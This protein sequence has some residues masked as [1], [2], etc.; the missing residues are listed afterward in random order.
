MGS[1]RIGDWPIR[2]RAKVGE[3]RDGQDIFGDY[4]GFM[5]IDDPNAVPPY[6]KPWG[7]PAFD[8][9][10]GARMDPGLS[11]WI[12]VFPKWML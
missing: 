12:V 10:F 7:R 5:V 3:I 8:H 4:S 11:S 9:C 2:M 6:N 1:E